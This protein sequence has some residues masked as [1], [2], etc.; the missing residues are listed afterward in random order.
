[1]IPT[2]YAH[3]PVL[4]FVRNPWS[5]YVSWYA[6]Q[7]GRPRPNPLYR[8][9]SNEGQLDFAATISN[10]LDLST[11]RISRGADRGLAPG[12]SQPRTQLARL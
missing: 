6:F 5:Y 8:V 12:I 7:A 4:G 10:M 1:M 11:G 3:L 2:A 9:L